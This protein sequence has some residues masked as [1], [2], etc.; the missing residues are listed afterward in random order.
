M[1]WGTGNLEHYVRENGRYLSMDRA[2]NLMKQIM[3]GLS[4][5]QREGIIH[6]DI[7]PANILIKRGPVAMIADFGLW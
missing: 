5:L 6:R 4:K 2:I 1:I 3:V 7:K